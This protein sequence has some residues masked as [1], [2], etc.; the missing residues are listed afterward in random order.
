M[1]TFNNEPSLCEQRSIKDKT[2]GV[3]ETISEQNKVPINKID[4]MLQ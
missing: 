3:N 4:A 1:Q 2:L